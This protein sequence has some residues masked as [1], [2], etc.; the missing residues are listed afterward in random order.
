[1][2]LL[3]FFTFCSSC[4]AVSSAGAGVSVTILAAV[5]IDC[6]LFFAALVPLFQLLP[7]AAVASAACFAAAAVRASRSRQRNA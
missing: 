3:Y 4:V 6:G 7:T 5:L 1:M 2:L